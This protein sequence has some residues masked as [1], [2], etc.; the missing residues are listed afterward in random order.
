MNPF[1]KPF[2]ADPDISMFSSRVHPKSFIFAVAASCGQA[3]NRRGLFSVINMSERFQFMF[4]DC[5][6]WKSV[7]FALNLNFGGTLAKQ[8]GPGLHAKKYHN[9]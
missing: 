4:Q 5:R 3:K 7:G 8:I 2:K 1:K 6:L 9:L